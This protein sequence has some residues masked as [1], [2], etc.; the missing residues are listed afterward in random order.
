MTDQGFLREEGVVWETLHSVDGDSCFCDTDFRLSHAPGGDGGAA[1][2]PPDHRLQQRQVDQVGDTRGTR[3]SRPGRCRFGWCRCAD[4]PALSL[5]APQDYMLALSLQRGGA[6]DPSVLGDL[7]LARQLQQEEYQHHHPQQQVPA[8]VS[9]GSGCVPGGAGVP[10]GSLPPSPNSRPPRPV[11][12]RGGSARSRIWTVPSYSTHRGSPPC[13]PAPGRVTPGE[14]PWGQGHSHYGVSLPP[15][16]DHP[17]L[18]S[19]LST[20]V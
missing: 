11:R 8:Q 5:C 12:R 13:P 4:P 15:G 16:R 1:A 14:T 20:G 18:S 19:G 7:E 6:Q 3:R 17:N 10:R 9:G 2:A